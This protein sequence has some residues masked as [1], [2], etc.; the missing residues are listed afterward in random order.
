MFV[1]YGQNF[2]DMIKSFYPTARA[3]AG[4]REIVVRC[5]ECG[6]SNDPTHAH[7]YISVPQTEN[8]I[9]L[10]NCKKCN[11]CGIVDDSFLRRYG[12][13]DPHI[14]VDIIK[15]NNDLFR[16]PT[17][18][19]LKKMRIYPLKNS[20]IN[21]Y[22]WNKAKLAYIN[23]RI[24]AQFTY[25]NILALKMFLNLGDVITLNNLPL[26]R[27]IRVC[28]EFNEHFVGFISYD[29]AYC[30]LRKYDNIPI[31][32]KIDKRY[33]NYD[34]VNKLDKSKNY[35]VIPTNINVDALEP[36]RIHVTEG[37]FD[38]LSV[39]YNLNRCNSYQNIYIAASGK[40]YK[41]ALQMI[42]S[43]TGIVNYEIH[44]YPDNDVTDEYLQREVLAKLKML[45]CVRYIHRNIHPNE[46]DYGV[47]IYRIND[48]VV[49][50][51]ETIV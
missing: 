19:Y 48:S 50:L 44:L 51:N 13:E 7:M 28:E 32:A 5:R 49:M 10:Y 43:D 14:L 24:G 36:I 38:I 21:E 4:N 11:A 37:V 1:L 34:F 30:T 9:S 27:S 3:V 26:T 31:Y 15:H 18:S 29:N 45:P 20:V 46:K 40:S 8:E 17:Y 12:C 35:Y 42:L 16:L 22:D 6:D 41:Q 2:I 23:N 33:M 25:E 47:P 39:Y